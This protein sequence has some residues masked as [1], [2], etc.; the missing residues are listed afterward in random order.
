MPE[1]LSFLRQLAGK[2]EYLSLD[3]GSVLDFED[4]IG[5]E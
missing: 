5:A 1:H 4:E 3:D 2:I